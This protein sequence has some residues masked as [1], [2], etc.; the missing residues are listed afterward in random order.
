MKNLVFCGMTVSG[1]FLLGLGAI[2]AAQQATGKGAAGGQILAR[3]GNAEGKNSPSLLRVAGTTDF[4]PDSVVQVRAPIDC[5]V[6]KVLVALGSQVKKGDPLLELF[7]TELAEGKNG[8][9]L[10]ISQWEHDKKMLELAVRQ[11]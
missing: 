4:V 11:W 3:P 2:V 9:L 10:A 6:D 1:L 5:R 7:S 8:Y